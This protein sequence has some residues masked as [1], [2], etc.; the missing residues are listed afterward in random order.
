[1]KLHITSGHYTQLCSLIFFRSN[2]TNDLS[3]DDDF[4]YIPIIP[5][6][7]ICLL[8]FIILIEKRADLNSRYEGKIYCLIHSEVILPSKLQMLIIGSKLD[9]DTSDSHCRIAFYG[10]VLKIMEDTKDLKIFK[11][12]NREGRIDRITSKNQYIVK[13]LFNKETDLTLVFIIYIYILIVYKYES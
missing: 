1:M 8:L 10:N 11:I 2:N 3:I 5:S 9:T 13:D 7:Y 4:E 12:K 6:I